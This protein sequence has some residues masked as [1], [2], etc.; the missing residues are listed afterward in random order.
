MPETDE[1]ETTEVETETENT[2]TVQESEQ[3]QD[4]DT[5]TGTD[6]PDSGLKKALKAERDARRAAERER[7]ALKQQLADR[8]KPAEELALE[9]A[10]REAEQ[11]ALEKAN[12]RI[13]RSELKA[14]A[15]GKVKRPDLLLKVTDLSAIEGDENGDPDPDALNDAITA[16]LEDYPEL[17]VDA[18]SKFSGSADQG[19]K[20]K[21]SKPG[22]L[23]REDLKNMTPDAINEARAQGRLKNLGVS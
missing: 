5:E 15:T 14:A 17:A 10:R 13:A 2:D 9:Q 12:A 7:N 8:D 22:Q 21:Q 4:T 11:A 23:T 1:V 18:P 6:E 3:E 19:S 16:F 20:G